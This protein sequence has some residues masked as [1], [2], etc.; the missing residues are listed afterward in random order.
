MSL[1][2]LSL[3][4]GRRVLN[5]WL[6]DTSQGKLQDHF[7]C[8]S[9]IIPWIAWYILVCTEEM[10]TLEKICGAL[11]DAGV[12]Y[13]IVG[14]YAVALHGAVRGTLD[15]DVVVRWTRAAL[16]R[17]EAALNAIGLVSR[18]PV[19]ARE[20][21]DF[22]DEYIRNRNL[23]AW[24]FSNPDDLLEQVDIIITD[25]LA[26]KRTK[27]VA[28]PTGPVHVLSVPDLIAMKRRSGQPQDLEDVRALEKLR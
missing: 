24:N 16:I 14:G 11:R 17:A 8:C 13:A 5:Q 1:R 25:D 19:T 23:T 2:S 26:G 21:Y 27:T 15:I 28:L 12:R 9:L 22:R 18:L 3:S 10:T 20:V 7:V 6:Q 4:K